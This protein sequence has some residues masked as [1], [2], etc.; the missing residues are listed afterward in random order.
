MGYGAI[1][2]AVASI[3]SSAIGGATSGGG[4]NLGEYSGRLNELANKY[5]L[6]FTDESKWDLNVPGLAEESINFG[7]ANAP[8]INEAN[9]R[10][11]QGLYQQAMPDWREVWGKMGQNTKA[12]LGGQ[13]PADVVDQI[14]NNA[15]Y[16]ALMTGI[17]GGGAGTGMQGKAL[18]AR[19]LGLTS[20]KLQQ[21]GFQQGQG[22]MQFARNFLMP[23]PV[24]PMSLLPLSHLISGL[25]WQKEAT[26]K[27]NEAAYT[28]KANAAAAGVG[29][30][31]QSLLSS[32]GGDLGALVN[33]LGKKNPQTG[34]SPFDSILSM[35]GG[36]GGGSGSTEV[37]G[38]N[39]ST[40]ASGLLNTSSDPDPD[41]AYFM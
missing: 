29:A 19:D 23:Q 38:L 36:G 27:A 21:Q 16:Q 4:P 7:I 33:A 40:G 15:A 25:E 26:F 22:M 11:L 10:Q 39:F 41:F 12:L 34:K 9:M 1:I 13:V 17:G 35:F 24:D 18:T 8:T 31:S 30:P 20:L 28:A 3:A 32:V 37:G 5:I 6:P 14:Q 2:S